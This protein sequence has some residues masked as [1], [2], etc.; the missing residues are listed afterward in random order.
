MILP[1]YDQTMSTAKRLIE[2]QMSLREI[3]S[4]RPT[5]SADRTKM[6]GTILILLGSFAFMFAF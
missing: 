5:F 1:L 6:S 4:H 3:V 2:H